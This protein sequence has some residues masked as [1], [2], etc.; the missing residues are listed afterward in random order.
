[1]TRD[2]AREILSV[3][4]P[5][6]ADESDPVFAEALVLARQDEELGAWF[7][8]SV[9]FDAEVR[10]QVA[11]AGAPEELLHRLLVQ[12]KI[13]QPIPWWHRRMTGRQFAAAAAL[14]LLAAV[15]GLWATQS[16]PSFAEFRR[17][18][19]DLAWGSSPHLDA[20]A[21]NMAEVHRFLAVQK[22]ST[23]FTVP[24]ALAKGGVRGCSVVAWHGHQLPVICFQAEGQHL[25]LVVA[26]RGLFEDGPTMVPVTDQWMAS[27]TAS[28]SKDEHTYILTGLNTAN[29]VKKFRKS[30]RWDW[31][32]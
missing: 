19:A 15:A 31:E 10:N 24:P 27:R 20:K 14:I 4:R 29:F 7:R 22:L 2:E 9:R 12:P 18:V 1:M 28:W 26:D 3:F 32:G 23:N 30:G 6:T 8:E 25:H 5:G 13:L 21:T 17:E 11:R 16:K